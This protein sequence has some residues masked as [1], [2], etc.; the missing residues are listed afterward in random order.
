MGFRFHTSG[1]L[2]GF[3]GAEFQQ[4]SASKRDFARR[5]LGAVVGVCRRETRKAEKTFSSSVIHQ[6]IRNSLR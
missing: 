2:Q 6:N 5:G 4:N 1:G 3:F